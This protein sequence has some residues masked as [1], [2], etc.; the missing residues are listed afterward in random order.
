MGKDLGIL[1]HLLD[2]GR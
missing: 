1:Q 2:V